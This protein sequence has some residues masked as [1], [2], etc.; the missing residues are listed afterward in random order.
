MDDSQSSIE[1][2]SP[3]V[4]VRNE[5]EICDFEENGIIHFLEILSSE[6]LL[7]S[8]EKESMI[9]SKMVAQVRAERAQLG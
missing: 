2:Q 5:K 1:V 6:R 4:S 9:L 3:V 7:S 8:D